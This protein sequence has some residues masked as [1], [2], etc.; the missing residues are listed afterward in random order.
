[1][2]TSADVLPLIE[3]YC[4]A[5]TRQ[6]RETW[7]D[8]FTDDA[9]QEDPVG[10]PVNVGRDAIGKFF[11]ENVTD[12]TLSVAAPPIVVG[13]EV[14]AFLRVDIM[15]GDQKMELP[16]IVDHIILNEEGTKFTSLRAFFDYSELRPA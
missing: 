4:A 14:I 15:M 6:D 11:D 16:R 5:M 12:L 13:N 7:L 8:C 9:R 1:M 2:P 3:R 10:A